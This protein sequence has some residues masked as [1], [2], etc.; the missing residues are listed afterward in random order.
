MGLS[1]VQLPETMALCFPVAITCVWRVQHF[2]LPGEV[3]SNLR[4][5][6]MLRS[7]NG[8]TCSM[9]STSRRRA[10]RCSPT[11]DRQSLASPSLPMAMPT[12]AMQVL[13]FQWVQASRQGDP[14]ATVA[15]PFTSWG[16]EHVSAAPVNGFFARIG[17]PNWCGHCRPDGIARAVQEQAPTVPPMRLMRQCARVVACLFLAGEPQADAALQDLASHQLWSARHTARIELEQSAG[18][19][20]GALSAAQALGKRRWW[21]TLPAPCGAN[22][23]LHPGPGPACVKRSGHLERSKELRYTDVETHCAHACRARC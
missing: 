13:V 23:R 22:R 19:A 18:N 21:L 12:T 7:P 17:M 2:E 14:H 10:L 5:K 9:C 16:D 15:N 1:C 11:P 6:R 4:F 3:A 20:S 8:E